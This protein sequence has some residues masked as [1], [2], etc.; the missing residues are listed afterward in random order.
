LVPSRVAAGAVVGSWGVRRILA[1]RFKRGPPIARAASGSALCDRRADRRGRWYSR[2]P[3]ARE[4]L[5]IEVILGRHFASN[6]SADR[7]DP[8]VVCA[9]FAN[10]TGVGRGAG[11]ARRGS[12]GSLDGDSARRLP[13]D[14][15]GRV[16]AASSPRA[17]R[18]ASGRRKVGQPTHG[19]RRCHW[20]TFASIDLTVDRGASIRPGRQSNGTLLNQADPQSGSAIPTR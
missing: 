14:F 5:V 3:D 2:K 8:V 6:R 13:C 11:G 15:T 19:T 20:K 7:L 9:D 1:A 18:E 16:R 4:R 12:R 17:I 10:F